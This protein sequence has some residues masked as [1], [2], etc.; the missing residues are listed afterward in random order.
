MLEVVLAVLG[1]G[2]VDW[3]AA[4]ACRLVE[5]LTINFPCT[6][7]LSV[8]FF[9]SLVSISLGLSAKAC[10]QLGIWLTIS[11]HV[12]VNDIANSYVDYTEEALILLLELLLVE[13]LNC[14]HTVL[15]CA[16]GDSSAQACH[17]KP[18]NIHVKRFVPVWIQG[19]LDDLGGLGLFPTDGRN[20]K[21]VRE[22]W[23]R[24]HLVLEQVTANI[25]KT[26]RLYSPSAAMTAT[27][28]Y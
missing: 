22:A 10:G 4:G 1:G 28:Q 16:P 7:R 12:K 20:R 2:R 25:R 23:S 27:S 9:K 24:Q 15:I 17:H 3:F 5:R 13:D 21:W 6:T 11:T 14:Q 18:N 19:L 8:D 26:S